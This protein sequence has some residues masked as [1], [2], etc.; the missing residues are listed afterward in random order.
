MPCQSHAM[1]RNNNASIY[2]LFADIESL[3]VTIVC[4][5]FTDLY[6]TTVTDKAGN[7]MKKSIS[8]TCRKDKL[9][10]TEAEL[11]HLI[12]LEFS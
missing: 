8:E 1:S 12:L 7:W 4:N 3:Y 6:V 11:Y 9:D 10:C 5:M 2:L